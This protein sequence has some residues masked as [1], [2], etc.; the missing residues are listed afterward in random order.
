MPNNGNY[1]IK[2]LIVEHVQSRFE[3]TAIKHIGSLTLLTAKGSFSQ[4]SARC[5]FIEA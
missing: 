2:L 4:L 3:M 1:F 5:S